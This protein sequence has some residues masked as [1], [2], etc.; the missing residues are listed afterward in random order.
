[1]DMCSVH[2][3]AHID[4]EY[5]MCAPKLPNHHTLSFTTSYSY[6]H[7]RDNCFV[8]TTQAAE[9]VGYLAQYCIVS[10][11][12]YQLGSIEWHFPNTYI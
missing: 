4:C 6:I 7:D 2:V 5:S 1:M 10:Q 9:A 8:Y 11:Y 12:K 3:N